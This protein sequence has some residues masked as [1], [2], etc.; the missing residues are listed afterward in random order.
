[1][2]QDQTSR[3]RVIEQFRS[4]KLRVIVATD[5]AGRGLDVKDIS[6]GACMRASVRGAAQVEGRDSALLLLHLGLTPPPPPPPPP[7]R[8]RAAVFNFDFPLGKGGVEDYV[9]R[10]GRTGRAGALGEAIT[11]FDP[12][13][14][15][16]SAP[17]LV[18]VMKGAQQEIPEA[19]AALCRGSD[20]RGGGG[21]G[22]RGG[23]RGGFGGGRGG[24][25]GGY[26]GGRSKW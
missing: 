21:F 6:H 26:G 1:M 9:H 15:K 4:G 12:H 5:V 16:R 3:S 11:F 19:L 14:D 17:E 20:R 7:S 8:P 23:G 22:G 25:R 10:I 24:G 2:L 18:A 13:A